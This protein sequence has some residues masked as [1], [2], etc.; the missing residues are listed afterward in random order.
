MFIH[1]TVENDHFCLHF[2]MQILSYVIFEVF[3]VLKYLHR[4]TVNYKKDYITAGQTKKERLQFLHPWVC[5]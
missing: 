1:N 5:I 4:L 3:E 2:N